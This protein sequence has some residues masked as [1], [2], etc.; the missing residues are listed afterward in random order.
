MAKLALLA[1]GPVLAHGHS[2]LHCLDWR[3]PLE[4]PD[5]ESQCFGWPRGWP[6]FA[7]PRTF[8]QDIGRDRRPGREVDSTIEC[9][10]QEGPDKEGDYGA[11]KPRAQFEPGEFFVATWPAKNHCD[12]GSQRGVQLF[13]TTVKTDPSAADDWSTITSKEAWVA[14]YP[15]LER[16]YSNCNPQRGGVD[17]AF[18]HGEFQIPTTMQA[19]FYGFMWWW[20]FNQGEF[21]NSCAGIEIVGAKGPGAPPA[22]LNPQ[23]PN[24]PGPSPPTL[25]DPGDCPLPQ[26][27]EGGFNNNP[28]TCS[29]LDCTVDHH[30]C[31]DGMTCYHKNQYFSGCRPDCAPG[32]Y[33]QDPPQF[34]TPWD[35]EYMGGMCTPTVMRAALVGGGGGAGGGAAPGGVAGVS[36]A[37]QTTIGF[38]AGVSS[39][40]SIITWR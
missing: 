2:W 39:A 3:G 7:L 35:C 21:Y 30:C 10:G 14:M 9:D 5:D 8:G 24:A 16:S 37:R 23:N 22:Q 40:I 36:A 4:G 29:D 27:V 26:D 38:V 11:D 31:P 25:E 18:C 34:Q 12:V 20:E 28:T 15:E 13:F 1:G 19:G 32:I 17:R 6:P 33:D